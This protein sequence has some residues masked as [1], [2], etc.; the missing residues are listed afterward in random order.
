MFTAEEVSLTSKDHKE[1]KYTDDEMYAR[2]L[3]AEALR[4]QVRRE[5]E[6]NLR[7]LPPEQRRQQYNS[8]EKAAESVHL[9][10]QGM[11]VFSKLSYFRYKHQP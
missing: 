10:V 7:D 9:G 4:D 8:A 1:M 5:K 11:P 3:R 6:T 2:A